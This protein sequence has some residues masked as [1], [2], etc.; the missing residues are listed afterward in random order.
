MKL[1]VRKP[2]K[3]ENNVGSSS[4]IA[5][6]KVRHDSWTKMEKQ[7]QNVLKLQ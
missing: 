6:T 7:N 2:I 3:K 5:I 1:L 4:E